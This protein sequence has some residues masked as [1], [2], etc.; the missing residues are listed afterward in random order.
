M[1]YTYHILT[2]A[3]LSMASTS[4][5]AACE[6]L[7][8]TVSYCIKEAD[9]KE[10]D[11]P[12]SEPARFLCTLGDQE[13]GFAI[14]QLSVSKIKS[15]KENISQD[16][17]YLSCFK[18]SLATERKALNAVASNRNQIKRQLYIYTK[19]PDMVPR[20]EEGKEKLRNKQAVRCAAMSR[21]LLQL[22][23]KIPKL[24]VACDKRL[25]ELATQ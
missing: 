21:G 1:K 24:V 6:F 20:T 7:D 4:S 8:D 11:F 3:I 15:T 5:F 17:E 19:H 16:P 2:L 14:G 18:K 10:A 22:K 9:M 25:Q 13:P 12:I 23:S